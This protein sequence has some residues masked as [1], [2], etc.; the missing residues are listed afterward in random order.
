M[1]DA[2]TLPT[3]TTTP[4][5]LAPIDFQRLTL[6]EVAKIEEL[7]GLNL[8]AI[9]DESSPKGRL[10]AAMAYVASRRRGAPLS[11]DD[12]LG[13][14]VEQAG[15]LIGTEP[16]DDVDDVDDDDEGSSPENP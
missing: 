9:A 3:T 8:D 2:A 16:A 5:P 4:A 15:E 10:L 12:A 13:L 1:S 7:S 11:W 14:T 6:G